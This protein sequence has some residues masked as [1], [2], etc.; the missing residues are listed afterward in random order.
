MESNN[1]IS[2]GTTAG[3]VLSVMPNIASEDVVK[4]IILAGLGAIVSFVVSLLLKS[5]A[6]LKKK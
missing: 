2:V 1:T 5:F 3:T 6:K 4:T